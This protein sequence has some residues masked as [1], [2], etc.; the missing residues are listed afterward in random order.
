VPVAVSTAASTGFKT[1]TVSTYGQVASQVYSFTV[2]PSVATLNE[3]IPNQAEQGAPIITSPTCSTLPYC[4]IRLIGQ[5]SH[6]SSLSTATFGAGIT[7][8]GVTYISPTE[9]DAAITIDP[10]SY[11]G[12][13]LVTVTTP[14]VPCSDQPPVGVNIQGTSYPGCTPGVPTGTG[15]EIVSNF[16][17]SIIPGPAIITSISPATG[18]EGQE[19]IANITGDATHWAQNFTQFYISGGGYDIT[20]NSVV[21][22]SP[23]SATV[24]LSISPTANPGARS[25]YMVTNG[26]SLTDSGAFVVT[27]GIP[28]ISYVTPNSAV[29]GTTGLEVTIVGNQYAVDRGKHDQLRPRHHD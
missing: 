12:G 23:T 16:V 3:A 7:V 19:I 25:I 18:N 14:G 24:D 10:L 8:Q 21:I 9:V 29:Y 11:P 15:S 17:F 27:G 1:V 2:S 22:N 5:Y 20:I 6:F 26:E 4:T 13:R 28:A